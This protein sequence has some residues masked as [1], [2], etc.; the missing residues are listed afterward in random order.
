MP[1]TRVRR[2]HVFTAFVDDSVL[3]LD[4]ARDL[5]RCMAKLLLLAELSGLRIQP[6]KCVG[7]W[8]NTAV[9]VP[10][11]AGI[12]FLSAGETT[13]YLGVLIGSGDITTTGC[14]DGRR[15]RCDYASRV[16]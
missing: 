13:R 2:R 1:P 16:K 9:S 15:P 6:Q 8:L 12:P 4:Q 7:L 5:Q 14:A 11:W 3:F 10:E